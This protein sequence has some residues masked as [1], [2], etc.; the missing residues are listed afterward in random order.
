[1]KAVFLIAGRGRRLRPYTDKVPKCMVPLHGTPLLHTALEMTA[2]AGIREAVLVVGHMEDVI[3][4]TYGEAFAGIRLRYVSNPDYATTNNL[5]TMWLAREELNE[6]IVLLEGD[7]RYDLPVLQDLVSHNAANAAVVDD[8][9]LPMNGTVILPDP[10]RPGWS[11]R[12]VLGKDQGDDFPLHQSLKT[13][14]L[15]RLSGA[16]LKDH[17]VPALQRAV[18]GERLGDYYE[19]ILAHLVDN[20]GVELAISHV[21]K[22]RWAEIDNEAD[23]QFATELFAPTP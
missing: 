6:D 16:L 11:Q 1:M 12:M 18:D 13:V 8:F 19:A 14:N 3:R 15:Y 2:A 7:L 10:E 9:R 23:L 17:F 22:H 5:Y 4:E 20:A 21:G